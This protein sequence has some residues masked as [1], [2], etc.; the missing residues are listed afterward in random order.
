MSAKKKLKGQ[1]D[2]KQI[3]EW[4][5]LVGDELITIVHEG[6]ISYF[7][8]PGR[9]EIG[10]GMTAGAGNM[11][12]I[13]IKTLE[14]CFLGGDNGLFEDEE[15]LIGSALEFDQHVSIKKTQLG[16]L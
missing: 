2:E 8:K 5:N 12:E 11:L 4:K 15:A 1:V 3:A 10:Q 14:A 7:K 9:T 6:A 16:K 13:Q